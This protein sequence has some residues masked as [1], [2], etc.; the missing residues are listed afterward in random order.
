MTL[1]GIIERIQKRRPKDRLYKAKQAYSAADGDPGRPT[2]S[3]YAIG[4]ASP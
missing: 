4:A 2:N 3:T 1:L